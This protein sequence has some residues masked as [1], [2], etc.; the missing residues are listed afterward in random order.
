M[1][2]L[3]CAIH[4]FD[5]LEMRINATVGISFLLWEAIV[6]G[7][8]EITEKIHGSVAYMLNDELEALRNELEDIKNRLFDGLREVR[9]NGRMESNQ[10]L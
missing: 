4:D 7:N 1:E 10:G 2:K 6:D 5:R 3:S 9:G 8:F